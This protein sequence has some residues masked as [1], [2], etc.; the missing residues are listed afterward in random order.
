MAAEL[1]LGWGAYP[2]A[3]LDRLGPSLVRAEDRAKVDLL[4]AIESSLSKLTQLR[5]LGTRFSHFLWMNPVAPLLPPFNPVGPSFL[6]DHQE[7]SRHTHPTLHLHPQFPG[8]RMAQ[9]EACCN[10]LTSP[11]PVPPPLWLAHWKLATSHIYKPQFSVCLPPPGGLLLLLWGFPHSLPSQI[12]HHHSLG[13]KQAWGSLLGLAERRGGGC[14]PRVR[15]LPPPMLTAICGETAI[16]TNEILMS[17]ACVP[18]HNTPGPLPFHLPLLETQREWAPSLTPGILRFSLEP[19]LSGSN[20]GPAPAALLTWSPQH[21]RAPNRGLFPG[22]MDACLNTGAVCIAAAH[23]LL[24][25]V[26]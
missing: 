14:S 9:A 26:L 8:F 16:L 21:Y 25:T 15:S 24:N 5:H 11:A 10:V 2:S 17:F 19:I 22:L 3:R 4:S 12:Q 7:F 13:A 18:R 1:P 20:G 6:S 23:C